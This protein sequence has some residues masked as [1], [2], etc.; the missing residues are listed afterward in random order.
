MRNLKIALVSFFLIAF[1]FSE[2][3]IPFLKIEKGKSLLNPF[4]GYMYAVSQ[5][6]L[7][8]L[9]LKANNYDTCKINLGILENKI[10]NLEMYTYKLEQ[11]TNV[12][13]MRLE[14]KQVQVDEYEKTLNIVK[15]EVID[16]RSFMDKNASWFIPVT[17][18]VVFIAGFI[19]GKGID[20][21]VNNILRK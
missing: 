8:Y 10:K 18:V 6:Y 4:D 14:L 19:T 21:T 5:P 9:L 1:L 3:Q 16:D 20:I 13:N 7:D 15:K 17:A 11:F 12:M 2:D